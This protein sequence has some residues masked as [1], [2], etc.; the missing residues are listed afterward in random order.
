MAAPVPVGAE[1][2]AVGKARLDSKSGYGDKP[3]IRM[4]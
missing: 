2:V 4:T 1:A 3:L